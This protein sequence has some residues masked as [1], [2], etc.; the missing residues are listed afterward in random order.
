[1]AKQNID[2][3]AHD[4]SY[5]T[6]LGMEVELR[7]LEENAAQIRAWLGR[8]SRRGHGRPRAF[9]D[10][11]SR[12]PVQPEA[13]DESAPRPLK[14]ANAFPRLRKARWARQKGGQ[15]AAVTEPASIEANASTP[16]AKR[17]RRGGGRKGAKAGK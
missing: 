1:M 9:A 5:F 2:S 10:R 11:A 12:L 16:R 4:S 17:D 8:T 7:Q 15:V 14:R 13:A 3:L 6:R